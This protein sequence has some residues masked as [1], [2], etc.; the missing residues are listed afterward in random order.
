MDRLNNIQTKYPRL[1][2]EEIIS[3]MDIPQEDIDKRVELAEKV[4]DVFDWLFAF[5]VMASVTEGMIDVE[6][7]TMSV[8]YR[9]KDLVN[10]DVRYVSEQIERFS[11]DVVETTVENKDDDYFLSPQRADERAI[12][13]A[14]AVCGYEELDEAI[15]Q[16]KTKKTWVSE[17]LKSTRK[18]HREMDGKTI[19]IEEPF[20]FDDCEMMM[21]HAIEGTAR[22]NSNCLCSLSFS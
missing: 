18:W 5:V 21:P 20:H 13:E 14:N 1:D 16:G 6:Y 12:D 8:E 11:R 17:K 15:K 4:R 22:Q 3:Q 7:L 10:L 9:L 19:P 2:I